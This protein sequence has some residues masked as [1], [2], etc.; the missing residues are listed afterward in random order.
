MWEKH[1]YW[2]RLGTPKRWKTFCSYFLS[3]TEMKREIT[4]SAVSSHMYVRFCLRLIDFAV[5]CSLFL[6][7]SSGKG[8]CY[9]GFFCWQVDV[10][11]INNS[12][13]E[14]A[15]LLLESF[16]HQDII[17]SGPLEDFTGN[18]TIVNSFYCITL[19][20][21]MSIWTSESNKILEKQETK[22]LHETTW[23]L[24]HESQLKFAL[25]AFANKFMWVLCHTEDSMVVIPPKTIRKKKS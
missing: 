14:A 24:H 4:Q 23:R 17:K 21:Y 10:P 1:S 20:I 9:L 16:L 18:H 19:Y 2:I 11:S 25:L 13:S 8:R 15:K 7:V 5:S 6:Y 12:M 3:I 22:Y